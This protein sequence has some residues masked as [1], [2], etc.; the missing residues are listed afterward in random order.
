MKTIALVLTILAAGCSTTPEHPFGT[1]RSGADQLAVVSVAGSEV[2][3]LEAD[4]K[5]FPGSGT[6]D[7]Y[8][9]P[10]AHRFLVGLNWCP[11][12]QCITF[13]AF[14]EKPRVACIDAKAGAR[15]RVS[16][17]SP[18]PDWLPRVT[19]QASGADAKQIDSR[20]S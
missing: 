2:K 16:A 17:G 4:G 6:S 20:C 9:P 5:P 10:G 1:E 3:I 13:G 19:E 14:A 11:G 15:Y 8:L 12:G 7:F 18:G